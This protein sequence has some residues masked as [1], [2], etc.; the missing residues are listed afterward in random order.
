MLR[1]YCRH[2]GEMVALGAERGNFIV[3]NSDFI[4]PYF[5]ILMLPRVVEGSITITQ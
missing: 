2:K 4:H 1:K 3:L 5:Y